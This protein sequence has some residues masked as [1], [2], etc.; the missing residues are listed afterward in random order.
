M[1]LNQAL[2]RPVTVLRERDLDLLEDR[3]W[4]QVTTD[5]SNVVVLRAEDYS[6]EK[7]RAGH[8]Q[9]ETT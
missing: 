4:L 2:T 9:K 8:A 5:G 6:P 3:G 7:P 1:S